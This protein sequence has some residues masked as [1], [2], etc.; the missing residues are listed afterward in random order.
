[1]SKIIAVANQKGGVGKTTS[2]LNLGAALAAA[3]KRV[4]LV[5]LDP[6]ASLT[7]G[8]GIEP[9]E[10]DSGTFTLFKTGNKA[11][12]LRQN[13]YLAIIPTSIRLATIPQE[14][15]SHVNPNGI[16]RKA[17]APLS[18]EFDVMLLDTPP[19]LDRLTINALAAADYVIIPCQTQV[20]AMQGLQD[21][22]NTL[23][24]VKEL[25]ERLAVLAVLPTMY[26]GNRKVEQDALAILQEQFGELCQPPLNDRV[27]YLKASAEQRPVGN[28]QAVYW[29]ELAD[30]VIKNGGI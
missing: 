24:A 6:Q 4:L 23:E 8:V 18:K 10:L 29:Q 3:G 13:D 15:A 20:M 9:S 7:K 2:T 25:N 28:G 27:E 30:Y 14:I 1:M 11:E 22:A 17:L 16:L 12:V 5:D 19:N 26:T 21:F